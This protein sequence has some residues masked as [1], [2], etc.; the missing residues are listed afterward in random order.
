MDRW[1]RYLA[2]G[3]K[4][5]LNHNDFSAT[6]AVKKIKSTTG[7][8]G[9][10][11]ERA[12][13]EQSELPINIQRYLEWTNQG[14]FEEKFDAI[15]E[16]LDWPNIGISTLLGIQNQHG[17]TPLVKAI[18]MWEMRNQYFQLLSQLN[19]EVREYKI[20]MGYK[21]TIGFEP[22]DFIRFYP[23]SVSLPDY[24]GI[25]IVLE[26]YQF[27]FDSKQRIPFV[28]EIGHCYPR[29]INDGNFLSAKVD[30]QGKREILREETSLEYMLYE[31][32][33]FV[34]QYAIQI[35][36]LASVYKAD[37]ISLEMEYLP[38]NWL[39]IIDFDYFPLT[40]KSKFL[41]QI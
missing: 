4:Q 38:P 20:K 39:A 2:T 32:E 5:F 16:H 12:A 7:I 41:A 36:N 10:V 34:R 13:L 17:R 6:E 24:R 14:S 26:V 11:L 28:V 3:Q 23:S 29:K 33:K 18:P 25:I 35:R 37:V 1:Y 40:K 8:N 15:V 27:D 19:S 21:N 31:V 9:K 22:K 30:L